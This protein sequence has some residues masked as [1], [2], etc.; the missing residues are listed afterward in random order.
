L[1]LIA[2]FPQALTSNYTWATAV[3][4]T[5]GPLSVNTTSKANFTLDSFD[6]SQVT[7]GMTVDLTNNRSVWY[8]GKDSSLRQYSSVNSSLWSAQP[9]QPASIWPKADSPSAPL[10]ACYNTNQYWN[11]IYYMVNEHLMEVRYDNFSATNGTWMWAPAKPV[12]TYLPEVLN[13]TTGS[14]GGSGSGL[15]TGAQAGIGVGVAVG[16]LGLVAAG[17]IFFFHRRHQQRD[18]RA[19]EGAA[20]GENGYGT[21]KNGA[22]GAAAHP[23]S[24][25][26]T[27]RSGASSGP[28]KPTD[29]YEMNSVSSTPNTSPR[30]DFV[31]AA[32]QP[33]AGGRAA[34]VRGKREMETVERPQELA[35]THAHEIDTQGE[36]VERKAEL[37]GKK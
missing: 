20:N 18:A 32:Q 12:G 27:P 29:D 31:A 13:S 4:S 10:A 1:T 16:V 15:S 2:T 17:A 19:A 9:A 8:I 21:V 3:N 22:A 28:W 6:S 7:L 5:V 14:G 30:A 11:R 25:R 23:D 26:G 24:L 33:A 34:P 35:G 37:E 36:E